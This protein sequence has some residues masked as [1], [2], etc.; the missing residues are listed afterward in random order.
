MRLDENAF[1]FSLNN[2]IIYKILIP[3][4]AIRLTKYNKIIIGNNSKSNGFYFEEN[5][6]DDGDYLTILKFMIFKK[7]KN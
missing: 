2:N 1:V 6:I 4:L 5:T 3:E 7:R